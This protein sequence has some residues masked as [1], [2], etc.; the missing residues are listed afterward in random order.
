[1]RSVLAALLQPQIV[2]L[3]QRDAG[4]NRKLDFG[5]CHWSKPDQKGA[6]NEDEAGG[7]S[8]KISGEALS[9]HDE[10]T[11]RC[12]SKTLGRRLSII[13]RFVR[14]ARH[15]RTPQRSSRRNIEILLSEADLQ[16]QLQAGNK[17]HFALNILTFVE[18]IIGKL[19]NAIVNLLLERHVSS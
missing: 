14:R 3:R 2:I 4:E 12:A 17:G 9:S 5:L 6:G 8:R 16:T 11:G 1:M 18:G 10:M 13:S 19:I 7:K 15:W